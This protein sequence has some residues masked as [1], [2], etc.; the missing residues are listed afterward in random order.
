MP[1]TITDKYYWI[2]I[3]IMNGMVL[4][5]DYSKYANFHTSTNIV[6]EAAYKVLD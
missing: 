5:Q 4:L 2:M 3:D 6:A 1:L